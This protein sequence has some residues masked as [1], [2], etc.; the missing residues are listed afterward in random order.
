MDNR[1]RQTMSQRDAQ[2]K[3]PLLCSYTRARVAKQLVSAPLKHLSLQLLCLRC[4]DAAP[5]MII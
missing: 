1:Q 3:L 5:L 4:R 2:M